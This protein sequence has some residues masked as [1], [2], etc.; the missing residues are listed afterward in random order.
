MCSSDLNSETPAWK[1]LREHAAVPLDMRTLFDEDEN[2]FNTFS[3][4]F[5]DIFVD[6][7]KNRVT[8]NTME[9]L[10]N[11]ATE[12]KV[13][14]MRDAMFGGEAINLTEKRAVLHVALRNR[15]NTPIMVD[16]TDVMPKVN[17]VLARMESVTERVRQGQWRGYTGERIRHVVNIGIGGSDL[18]PVMVTEALKPYCHPELKV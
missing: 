11:L 2:R 15:S 12:R 5:E 18:G 4:E 10:T 7:S 1:A 8:S 17:D 14:D 6:Y 16:G 9:L 3:E 13:T